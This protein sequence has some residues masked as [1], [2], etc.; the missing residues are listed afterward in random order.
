MEWGFESR[1]A[2]PKEAQARTGG[3]PPELA[4]LTDAVRSLPFCEL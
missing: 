4:Y 1:F 3:L 2:K